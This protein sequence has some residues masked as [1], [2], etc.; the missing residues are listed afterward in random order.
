MTVRDRWRKSSFS[1]TYSYHHG[2]FD[3]TEREFRGFG[4]V[5]QVD[6]ESF[7]EF[8]EDNQSS[9]HITS[10]KTLYQPPVKTVTWY[11]TGVAVDRA[12]IL[13]S[14]AEEYFPNW[15]ENQDPTKQ[16]VLGGFQENKLPEPDLLGEQLTADEWREAMRAC[17]GMMLRQE[18]YELDNDALEKGI[19][20]P[21]RLFSTAYHNCAIRCLQPRWQNQHA[22]FFVTESEAVTY[23]YELDL[24]PE[25]LT[26]D[27]R[28]THQLHLAVD[29]V[30]N[31]LQSVSVVY[32]RYGKFDDKTLQPADIARIRNLQE[33]LHVAYIE[34]HYT[35]D[36]QDDN[37]HRLR[38]PYEVLTYELTGIE[39]KGSA[40]QPGNGPGNNL[41]FNLEELRGYRLSSI[42]Q[43]TGAAIDEIPYHHIPDRKRPQKRLVEHARTLYFKDDLSEWL[44][45]GQ[46]GRLGLV[47]EQY[48]LALTKDLLAAIFDRRLNDKISAQFGT[49]LD[50][51]NDPNTSGYLSGSL[52]QKRFDQSAPGE[53]WIRSGV[54]GFKKDAAQHFYLP[55]CYTDPFGN[56]TTVTYDTNDLF[57]QST[58]DHFDN[59]TTVTR[60][61]YRVLAPKEIEDLNTNR[62]EAWFDGLGMVVAVAQKGKGTEGDN[63]DGFDDTLA[64]PTIREIHRFFNGKKFDEAKARLW[65][66]NASTRYVYSFGETFD[67]SGNAIWS[68]HPASACSILREKHVAQLK[69]NKQNKL[70]PLQVAFE[71]SDGL[72][73]VLM[74][75]IQ[76]EPEP[77]KKRL[78]WIT[79]GK[80]ILNNKG[81]PVKQ[82]EPYF[83]DSQHLCEEPQE[84]GV[85]PVMYYDALGRLIHTDFPNGTFSRVEFSPWYAASFDEND[86]VL[87]SAWYENRGKPD[88]QKDPE[89]SDPEKRATWLAARHANTPSVT[90]LDSL[91]RQVVSIAYNRVKDAAGQLQDVKYLTFTRLDTEGKPLWIINARGNRV[92]Q[93]VTPPVS[94]NKPYD[95]V[96]GYTPC[97]D[98]AGNLLFQHSMDAGDRWMLMDAAGK[99]ML[100]WDTNEFQDKNTSPAIQNRLF[101]TQYDALHR[102]TAHWL[103]MDGGAAQMIERFEY[104][105]TKDKDA[106]ALTNNLIGQAVRHY[107]PSGLT[108]LIRRDFKGNVEE[109]QRQ[110]TNQYQAAV[111]DWQANPQSMLENETYVQVTEYDA[112]NRMNS[113]LQLARCSR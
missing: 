49:A 82:F 7:G 4:R 34:N 25:F 37:N 42:Y 86:T 69:R 85:T 8:Q 107:D 14:Y 65:L 73:S 95:P 28:I 57:V 10:D 63:L 109:I 70:N 6:V 47:Y 91:G 105:D 61:D 94:D 100:A 110:L 97:Y 89:P 38:L 5:E 48:R 113:S 32:P 51:L 60:F 12:R 54:A 75:K 84:V 112:L 99:P 31:L 78:R 106:N 72:G 101:F 39:P 19:H 2:Y 35:N 111:I 68:N 33:E 24:G 30:G 74:K 45:L 98:I 22:V 66:G 53:Y 90:L 20:K 13:S 93:Y 108:Q 41:Y 44:P 103:T 71:C 104:V 55:C 46:L 62:I 58:T 80:T 29:K 77:D 52:L 59:S 76:A 102:P 17:K 83:C 96:T 81:K 88:P 50:R 23:H 64:N 18:I 43:K 87:D 26:P 40:G 21:V 92:M 56:T 3:G 36:V 67:E 15:L 27:P 16:N 79:S 1:T 9:P 11:H